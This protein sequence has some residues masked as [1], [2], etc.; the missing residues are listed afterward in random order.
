MVMAV[1][2]GGQITT[3]KKSGSGSFHTA[4]T[5]EAMSI[6]VEVAQEV[7]QALKAKLTQEENMGS[8]RRKF[9]FLR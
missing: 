8:S 2:P 5:N 7:H 4:S 9:G 6:G 3:L 1:K